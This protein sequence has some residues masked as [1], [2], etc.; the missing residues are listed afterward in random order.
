M[1][2]VQE[3]TQGVVQKL[4]SIMNTFLWNGKR[5]KIKI[6]TLQLVKDHR[7]LKLDSF[8]YR[9]HPVKLAWIHRVQSD[10]FTQTVSNYFLNDISG[11]IL[12]QANL[13]STDVYKIIHKDTFWRDVFRAWCRFNYQTFKIR[14]KY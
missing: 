1:D 10:E 14:H 5:P 6:D 2:V 12:W 7:G 11:N 13:H 9:D 3:I 4:N 8:S